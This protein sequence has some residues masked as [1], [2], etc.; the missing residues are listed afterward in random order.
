MNVKA[1]SGASARFIGEFWG[2]SKAG[3]V[4]ILVAALTAIPALVLAAPVGLIFGGDWWMIAGAAI[5][6]FFLGGAVSGK[7]FTSMIEA[8]RR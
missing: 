2:C 8:A 5:Y 4:M 1:I 7:P 3:M 6:P